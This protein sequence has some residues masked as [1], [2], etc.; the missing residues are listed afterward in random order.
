[1]NVNLIG[2]ADYPTLGPSH[3]ELD[4]ERLMK[5][6]K[7]IKPFFLKTVMKLN[8]LFTKAIKKMVQLL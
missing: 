8:Q 7:N 3:A 6:F 5:L 4:G 1:V 2:F